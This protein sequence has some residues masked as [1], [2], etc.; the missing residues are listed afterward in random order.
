MSEVTLG[1]KARKL[2]AASASDSGRSYMA[3]RNTCPHGDAGALPPAEFANNDSF[4]FVYSALF[5]TPTTKP[6]VIGASHSSGPEPV[7]PPHVE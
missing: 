7:A 4:L 3:A 6:F 2:R 5:A 1:Q